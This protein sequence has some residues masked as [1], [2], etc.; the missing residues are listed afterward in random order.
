MDKAEKTKKI[1]QDKYAAIARQSGQPGCGCCCSDS[2]CDYSVFNDSYDGLAGYVP[3]ADLS[4]GCGIPTQFADIRLGDTVVDLGSGAG[5]DVFI[6]RS[7]VGENGK[8]IGIDMTQEMIAKAN[9]NNS[10]LGYKNIEFKLGDIEALPL[11]E[12]SVNVVVS[13]CVLNLVPDKRKAFSEIFRILKPG[14]HFC[15]SDV[16]LDGFL[17][18]KLQQAA[19]MYTGC[20]AGAM[21]KNEYLDTIKAAGFTG[22]A[23]KTEKP[24]ELPDEALQDL[25]SQEKIAAF[26]QSRVEIIS[27]TVVGYKA[28]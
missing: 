13:N 2:D 23:V 25:L 3:D 27:V 19:E 17:P 7:L 12:A 15:V 6:V 26:R 28:G 21:Q 5:N 10:K 16:V 14:A 18:K 20:V 22:I 1:V 9:L 11:P 24:I 8:V 4:L